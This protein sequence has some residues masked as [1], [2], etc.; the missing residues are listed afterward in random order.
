MGLGEPGEEVPDR[1]VAGKALQPQ[2]GVRDLVGPQP[3]A[4]GEAARPDDDRHQAG[5]QGVG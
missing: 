1:V 5:R 4:V 3:F 2:H